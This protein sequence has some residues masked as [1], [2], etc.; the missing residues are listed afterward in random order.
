MDLR[1]LA[2]QE[3]LTH[4]TTE[5]ADL[6]RQI[7]IQQRESQQIPSLRGRLCQLRVKAQQE[8]D[9]VNF[10][11]THYQ[12]H[13]DY[14]R[15]YPAFPGQ[16]WE[17]TLRSQHN[18][19]KQRDIVLRT[20][21][22]RMISVDINLERHKTHRETVVRADQELTARYER[23]ERNCSKL[24]WI[25]AK[26]PRAAPILMDIHN[27]ELRS[28]SLKIVRDNNRQ[29][30]L[31]RQKYIESGTIIE[32]QKKNEV[33]RLDR[34][35]E[36]TIFETNAQF[37]DFRHISQQLIDI[38]KE[39][40]VVI[41]ASGDFAQESERKLGALQIELDHDGS[42]LSQFQKE[43]SKIESEIEYFPIR[44][45]RESDEALAAISKRSQL[46]V[47]LEKKIE[48]LIREITAKANHPERLQTLTIELETHWT[49]C[50]RLNTECEQFQQ[51]LNILQDAV[52]R[53]RQILDQT[54]LQKIGETVAET[55]IKCLDI[56]YEIAKTQ[57][58]SMAQMM[59]G[60]HRE[61][62][63]LEAEH[64][65]FLEELHKSS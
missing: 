19:L 44:I 5:N 32:V 65:Q 22:D 58:A 2:L 8:R 11:L 25:R 54:K 35:L 29:K 33:D 56:C 34:T 31:N 37:L 30:I 38:K 23:L 46:T 36:L 28:D 10:E 6:N 59:H 15:R 57:N 7:Q 12:L 41:T 17:D 9:S 1:F 16:A 55:G 48:T 50:E 4:F 45:E 43:L 64:S 20:A 60:I 49:E 40:D 42:E 13:I 39:F 24:E 51:R 21:V 26:T 62:E 52:E 18:E 61:L 63:I 3:A 14:H 27:L 53:K 47:E